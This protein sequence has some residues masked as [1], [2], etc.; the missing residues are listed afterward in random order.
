MDILIKM[1]LIY[2]VIIGITM[3]VILKIAR[4]KISPVGFCAVALISLVITL[5]VDHAIFE[6]KGRT[7]LWTGAFVSASL[8]VLYIMI[9][10]RRV[11]KKKSPRL[12]NN[13]SE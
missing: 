9:A 5:I 10:K 11:A 12:L 1:L 7:S 6:V 2:L 8:T 4:K 13:D 3:E